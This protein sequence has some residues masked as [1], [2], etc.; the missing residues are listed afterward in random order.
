VHLASNMRQYGG[1]YDVVTCHNYYCYYYYYYYY[2]YYYYYYFEF[3]A[4]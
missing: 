2:C 4:V 3:T 1:V